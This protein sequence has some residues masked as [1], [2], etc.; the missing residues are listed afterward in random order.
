MKRIL[1]LGLLSLSVSAFAQVCEVDLVYRNN[2][3]LRTFRA[4][5]DP[6][7]CQEGMKECRKAIRFDY[8]SNPQYPSTQLDCLRAGG[9]APTPQP[10][11]NPYP[12]PQPNPYPPQNPY[13]S[14]GV[15][16]TGIVEDRLFTLSGRDGNELFMNCMNSRLGGGI[17]DELFFSAN[18]NR[19]VSAIAQHYYNEEQICQMLRQEAIRTVQP[20]YNN[21][22][23]VVGTLEREPF[24]IYANDRSEL[25][26]EC[27][28]QFTNTRQ[29]MTD[30]LTYA[31]NG[32]SFQRV[33][34]SSWWNSPARACKALIQNLDS[35][36]R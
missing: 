12:N 6:A 16:V 2:Q 1:A 22:I 4:Y 28:R 9:S 26:T 36:I 20:A 17:V 31:Y 33:T 21:Y 27:I 25:L 19:F 13:P 7:T 11:P 29:G 18:N 10:Q 14:Y 8:S 23:N 3:I 35:Q 5:G 15:S 34:T 32:S 24:Q 30:E